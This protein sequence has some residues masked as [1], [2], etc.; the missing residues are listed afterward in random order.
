MKI[1]RCLWR[2]LNRNVLE[3]F[4]IDG[5]RSNQRKVSSTSNPKPIPKAFPAAIPSNEAERLEALHRYNIL[6]TSP[7]AAFDDLTSLASYICGT[8][9]ALVS[10]VDAN[11]QKKR[12]SMN[13]NLALFP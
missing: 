11:R 9:I 8:P 13:S 2:A 7:E 6:D 10:L 3:L 1:L 4:R 5:Y 12:N